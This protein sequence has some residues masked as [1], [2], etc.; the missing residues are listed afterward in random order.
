M[1]IAKNGAET[2]LRTRM[3]EAESVLNASAGPG[4]SAT[5]W[6]NRVINAIISSNELNTPIKPIPVVTVKHMQHSFYLP[7]I[8]D[9]KY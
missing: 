4:L 2:S 5:T 3:T 8:F 6:Q 9:I 7:S 1:L